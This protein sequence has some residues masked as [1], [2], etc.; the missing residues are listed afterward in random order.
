[1]GGSVRAWVGGGKE[2]QGK[3][4]ERVRKGQGKKEMGEGEVHGK[5]ELREGKGQGKKEMGREVQ[6]K[7]E[8]RAG[9]V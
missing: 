9:E 2:Q 5:G 7:G 4:E 6:V 1:M 3:V 8:M